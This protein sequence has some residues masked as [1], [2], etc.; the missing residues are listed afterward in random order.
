MYVR[1]NVRRND[2]RVSITYSVV[3]SYRNEDGAV[4]HRTITSL[5]TCSTV[6]ERLGEL[7]DDLENAICPLSEVIPTLEIQRLTL[8]AEQMARGRRGPDRPTSAP[9]APGRGGTAC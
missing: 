9:R 7:Q 5:G 8:I 1:R 6:E 3:E 4:R 2:G